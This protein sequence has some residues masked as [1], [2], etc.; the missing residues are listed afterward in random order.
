MKKWSIEKTA[1]RGIVC[2]EAFLF[3]KD[4]LT[5]EN[6]TI[7][8]E[9]TDGE[10]RK[11]NTARAAVI[12]ELQELSNKNDIFR[13]HLEVVCDFVLE[14]KVYRKIRTQ[15]E[16][17]QMAV[18][19]SVGEIAADFARLQDAYIKERIADIKDVGSRLMT[20]L[21]GAGEYQIPAITREVILV[22]EELLPSDMLKIADNHHIR[23]IITEEG[24]MTSHVSIMAKNLGLP[25]LV[26]VHGI[27]KGIKGGETVC[28]D[29]EQGEIIVSP[30]EQTLSLYKK[31]KTAYET[32]LRSLEMKENLQAETKDGRKIKICANVGSIGEIKAAL[33]NRIETVGLFRTE[34]LYMNASGF[35]TEE[36]QLAVYKEAVRLCPKGV[37]VRT[38]DFGGDKE[39]P[40]S[41]M[42]AEAN[43]FLGFRGIRI[44]LS[45]RERFKE[46]LRAVLQAADEGAVRLLLPMIISAEEL[47]EV[48]ALVSL[49]RQELKEEKKGGMKHVKIGVMVETPAAVML[50]EGLAKE[51]DFLSIGTNDLTQYML[52]VDRGNKKVAELF[53]PFH[54]AV[55]RAVDKIIRTGKKY[56][57]PVSMCGELAGDRRAAKLLV[58]MGLEEFSMS[59][60]EASDIRE[61]I[62]GFT[63]KEAQKT[64]LQALAC[65]T[66]EEVYALLEA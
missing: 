57:I 37:T 38:P 22:C 4:D 60:G 16:N 11:F 23:G 13:A 31:R 20:A 34:Q 39:L 10:I 55:L 26:G 48:K 53:Q 33:R 41:R 21:K 12:E 46:Q 18:Y 27:L 19:R 43:P 30:D 2:A 3:K 40:N 7:T 5:P 63:Y 58:G 42:E 45:E 32:R 29:A 47:R 14:E 9:Q 59:P 1:S 25:A 62:C 50:V 28:M 56:Q 61:Q 35:P 6:R 52:A 36:E 44:S 65:E 15:K 66:P 51:A 54:P 49:C 8:E 64:A 17:V 24:G